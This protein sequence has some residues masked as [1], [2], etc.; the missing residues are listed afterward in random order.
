MENQLV[1]KDDWQIKWFITS[2]ITSVLKKA[3]GAVLFHCSKASNLDTKHQICP[4][5]SESW[6]KFQADK[7]N[8]RIAKC[9][10]GC[11]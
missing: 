7:V 9:C 8:N 2:K 11:Y 5:S 4:H 10:Q 3:I 6:C 1:E